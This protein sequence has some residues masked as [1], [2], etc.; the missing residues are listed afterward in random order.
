MPPPRAN[1]LKAKGTIVRGIFSPRI[2]AYD[3]TKQLLLKTVLKG[4]GHAVRRDDLS[5][6]ERYCERLHQTAEPISDEVV[7]DGLKRLLSICAQ[8]VQ[9]ADA[10]RH[11]TRQQLLEL[12][13]RLIGLPTQ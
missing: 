6:A 2:M 13:D 9:T 11:E 12:I 7:K 1:A 10:E 4:L 5:A 3:T 8:W